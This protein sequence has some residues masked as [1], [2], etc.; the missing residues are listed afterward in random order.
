MPGW[1]RPS[2]RTA[3]SW[4]RRRPALRLTFN[5]PVVPLVIRLIL[6]SGLTLAPRSVE[7]ENATV[8]IAGYPPLASGTHVLSWRVTS[9]DGHPVGGS[10]V[11][12]IGSPTEQPAA[13]STAGPGVRSALWAARLALYVGLFVGVGGAFFRAW[14]SDPRSRSPAAGALIAV[15]LVRADGRADLD[16]A[17]RSRRARSPAVRLA[18]EGC[19]GSGARHRLRSDGCRRRIRSACRPGQLRDAVVEARARHLARGHAR[20]WS[21]AGAQRARQHRPAATGQPPGI[22]PARPV[23]HLLGRVVAAALREPAQPA[24]RRRAGAFLARGSVCGRSAGRQRALARGRAARAPRCAVVHGLW[25]DS[26]VQARCRRR[27]ADAGGGQS[28]SAG[29]GCHDERFV[30]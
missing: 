10:L 4:L 22:V 8:V 20:R 16:R 28:L 23:R 2:L 6:P 27:A 17:A 25:T 13:Q 19:L 18:S 30:R 26:G 24:G 11:F 12:S 1:S 21:C 15:L 5:E 7:V 14:I 9:A 29:A 3:R